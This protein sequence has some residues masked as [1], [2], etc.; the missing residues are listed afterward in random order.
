MLERDSENKRRID[1]LKEQLEV[2]EQKTRDM[3]AMMKS[4]E[5]KL[6]VQKQMTQYIQNLSQTIFILCSST[7]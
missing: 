7:K 4:L 1:L 3:Q 2:N 5:E 6:E